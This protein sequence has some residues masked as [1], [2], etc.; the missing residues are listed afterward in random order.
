KRG[1]TVRFYTPSDPP[2]LDPSKVE[3]SQIFFTLDEVWSNLV[4]FRSTEAY[5]DTTYIPDLA[6]R[7]DV[8]SGGDVYTFFLHPDARWQNA[9]P[10][11]GRRLTAGDVKWSFDKLMDPSYGSLIRTRLGL[12]KEVRAPD[13]R[14][15]VL[16]LREAA[17]NVLY[18]IAW[19]TVKVW[20]R[21]VFERDGNFEK[22][23]LG[24]GSSIGG[25]RGLAFASSATPT[26]GAWG[27]T[28]SLC[29]TWT[30]STRSSSPTRRPT[31][32]P[33]GPGS[34]TSPGSPASPRPRSGPCAESGG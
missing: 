22:T 31:S 25:S 30:P 13:D 3:A 18:D 15:L 19:V 23:A 9:P 4:Q 21:E 14:T 32:R 11:N 33:S 20:P 5:T 24:S 6:E 34:W 2:T 10:M 17:N 1:G 12:V 29:R 28:A 16:Q 27:M 7:W 26:T 8:S